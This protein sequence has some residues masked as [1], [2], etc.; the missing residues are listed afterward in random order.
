MHWYEY[1]AKKNAKVTLKSIYSSWW[2]IQFLDKP[3]KRWEKT[4]AITERIRNH[5]V[6]EPIYDQSIYI[7]IYIYW[8]G[9][10][11]PNTEKSKIYSLHK[12]IKTFL[13]ILQHILQQ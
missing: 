11:K 3:W 9:Y 13:S 10:V 4:I 1:R 8:Y 2:I 7:Y 6:S 5:L 12:K